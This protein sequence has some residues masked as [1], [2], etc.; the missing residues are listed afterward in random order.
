MNDTDPPQENA[1]N[2]AGAVVNN[3]PLSDTSAASETSKDRVQKRLQ[4]AQQNHDAHMNVYNKLKSELEN[5]EARINA[6]RGAIEQLTKSLAED[7]VDD[8]EKVL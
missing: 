8:V 6:F 2:A 3:N 7:F 4:L 5:V 1:E